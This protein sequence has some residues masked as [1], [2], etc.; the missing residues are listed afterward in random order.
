MT[1]DSKFKVISK[2]NLS[3]ITEI[4]SSIFEQLMQIWAANGDKYMASIDQF[5]NIF[6]AIINE[7]VQEVSDKIV[8]RDILTSKQPATAIP[9]IEDSIQVL[10]S[11]MNEFN[12]TR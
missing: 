9:D 1:L 12:A 6:K 7:I 11:F 4:M 8:I 5:E 2:G 3:K 10:E